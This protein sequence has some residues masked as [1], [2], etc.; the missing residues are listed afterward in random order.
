MK[1]IFDSWTYPTP[2]HLPEPLFLSHA[3]ILLPCEWVRSYD[4]HSF[5][6]LSHWTFPSVLNGWVPSAPAKNTLVL[7]DPIQTL[8]PLWSISLNTSMNQLLL[9]TFY[10]HSNIFHLPYIGL[11][12]W[13]VGFPPVWLIDVPCTLHRRITQIFFFVC[14]C[15]IPIPTK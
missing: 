11:L 10:V 12:H 7:W 9:S 2:S 8:P 4:S 3:S 13:P 5:L 6:L 15:I 1:L 14:E